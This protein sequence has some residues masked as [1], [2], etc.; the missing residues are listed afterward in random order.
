MM[1]EIFGVPRVYFASAP[2]M[3]MYG[4]GHTTGIVVDIGETT[5]CVSPIYESFVVTKAV[6]YGKVSGHALTHHML[7]LLERHNNIEF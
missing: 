1:F 5:T 6:Q 4:A 3:A 2:A 7:E